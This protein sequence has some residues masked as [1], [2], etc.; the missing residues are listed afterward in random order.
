MSRRVS[1][2]MLLILSNI[3]VFLFNFQDEEKKSYMLKM[4]LTL[5]K[6]LKCLHQKERKQL[7]AVSFSKW[8]SMMFVSA[9]K[10]TEN[11]C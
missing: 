5:I 8:M 6:D 10:S 7:L 11:K 4:I 9:P 3:L 1:Y 2:S